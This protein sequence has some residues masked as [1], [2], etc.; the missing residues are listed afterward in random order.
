[1]Y[2]LYQQD[3]TR[4]IRK[5]IG[6]VTNRPNT[7]WPKEVVELIPKLEKY[8]GMLEDYN[9]AMTLKRLGRGEKLKRSY[10]FLYRSSWWW[11]YRKLSSVVRAVQNWLSVLSAMMTRVCYWRQLVP[12]WTAPAPLV[13][14]H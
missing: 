2:G 5:V 12:E 8:Q 10:I 11:G 6:H 3:P 14:A 4:V 13:I 7:D 1:M 9:Q